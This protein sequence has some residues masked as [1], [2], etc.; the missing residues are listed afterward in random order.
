M[1][2]HRLP[3]ESDDGSLSPETNMSQ[4]IHLLIDAS[5][6]LGKSYKICPL[7]P[8]W[9]T[10]A[11]FINIDE[12]VEKTWI[13]GTWCDTPR[14]REIGRWNALNILEGI[15]GWTMALFTRVL[16]WDPTSVHALLGKVRQEVQDQEIHAYFKT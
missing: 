6:E 7:L 9:L 5:E 14:N 11:G 8:G 13:G 15:D 1:V 4:W 12:K 3:Y 16:G 2:E 10:D